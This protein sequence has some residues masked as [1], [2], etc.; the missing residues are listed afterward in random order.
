ME[1]ELGGVAVAFLGEDA[2]R[3]NKLASGRPIDLADLALLD[4]GRPRR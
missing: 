1:I 2:L 3:K 4:E